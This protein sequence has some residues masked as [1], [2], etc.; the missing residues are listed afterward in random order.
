VQ[1]ADKLEAEGRVEEAEQLANSRIEQQLA[2]VIVCLSV[3]REELLLKQTAIMCK[4]VLCDR[5]GCSINIAHF[6]FSFLALRSM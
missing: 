3:S 5:Y 4:S 6:L 2:K 1:E